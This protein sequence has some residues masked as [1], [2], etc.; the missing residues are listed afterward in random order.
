MKVTVFGAVGLLF[1][2]GCKILLFE[3]KK[4]FG[5]KFSWCF[6]YDAQNSLQRFAWRS[7]QSSIVKLRTSIRPAHLRTNVCS[8]AKIPRALS[9]EE[10][11]L[12]PQVS[13]RY[14]VPF[15]VAESARPFFDPTVG[16]DCLRTF[17]KKAVLVARERVHERQ[18][19]FYPDEYFLALVR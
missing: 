19:L 15:S 4:V 7:W 2:C 6:P 1:R 17:I 5:R 8:R 16:T 18:E 11:G 13:S 9:R 14:A 10:L 12:C 3:N